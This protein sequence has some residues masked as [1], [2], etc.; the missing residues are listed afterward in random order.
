MKRYKVCGNC[1]AGWNTREAFINDPEVELVGLQADV[2]NPECGFYLFNHNRKAC[3]STLAERVGVF[4]DLH[5]GTP[6]AQSRYGLDDCEGRCARVE[7]LEICHAHCRNAFAREVA[8]ALL[9][10][11]AAALR[12]NRGADN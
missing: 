9:E 7:D 5:D 2:E 6:H 11:H 12:K 4:A 3:G 8:Q 10:I 1:Q